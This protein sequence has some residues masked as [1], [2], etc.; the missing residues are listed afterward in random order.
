VTGRRR[1][2]TPWVAESGTTRTPSLPTSGGRD[3]WAGPS[4][5]GQPE[6]LARPPARGPLG[7]SR[8]LRTSDRDWRADVSGALAGPRC[9]LRGHRRRTGGPADGGGWRVATSR[10]D[11]RADHVVVATGIFNRPRPADW[12]GRDEFCGALVNATVYRNP[13]PFRGRDVLVVGAGSTGLDTAYGISA[14]TRA[15]TRSSSRRGSCARAHSRIT[16]SDRRSL[17]CRRDGT[18]PIITRRRSVVHLPSGAGRREGAQPSVLT[19][20]CVSG[21]WSVGRHAPRTPPGDVAER[22]VPPRAARGAGSAHASGSLR[23]CGEMVAFHCF[24]SLR[25]TNPSLERTYGVGPS[26]RDAQEGR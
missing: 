5:V 21:Q 15:A 4:E 19:P 26:G 20:D 7:G 11:R 25:G 2:S 3:G 1:T 10:D 23:S 8:G 13:E 12:P 14:R 22:C 6:H 18:N 9:A 16:R 17:T 24:R